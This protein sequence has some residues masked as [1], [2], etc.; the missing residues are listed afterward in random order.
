[1]K[2]AIAGV[3]ALA[4][5]AIAALFAHQTVE[6]DLDYRR[7]IALGDEAVARGQIF[8][9]IE[10]FS[11][12]IALKPT[13]MLGYLKRGEA[14]QRRGETPET[15]MAAL[16]DLRMAFE[17]DP[18]APKA[19]EELG[20][21]NFKLQRY[22]NS[23]DSYEAYLRLDDQSATVFYKLA[24]AARGDGRLGRAVAAL[25][26]AVRLNPSFAEAH[27]MLGLCLRE[28]NQLS[29]ARAAFEQ[30][31][32]VAPAMISAREELADLH[33]LQRRSREEIEQLEALAALDGGKAERIIALGLAYMNAGN[34][35][36]AVTQL[37][38]ASERFPDHP[39]VPAALG[40]VWIRAAETRG[41]PTD[42]NKAIE[43][44]EPVATLPGA[45]SQ[46]LGLYGRALMLAGE[47]ARA[48]QILR[49]AAQRFPV[50]P[51]VLPEFSIAAQRMGHLQDARSSLVQYTALVDDDQEI[52][53]HA[54]R[55]ADLSMQLNDAA[56]AV[57]WYE[58]S[59]ALAR[60]DAS[61]LAREAEALMKAGR[62]KE[63][64]STIERALEEDPGNAQVKAVA[65]TIQTR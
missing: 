1:V 49:Q 45:T 42:I 64:E 30:A 39:G 48:E 25:Q 44:L 54:V 36:L 58:K 2:K 62:Q 6:R 28:R 61:Q 33:H 65:R 37:R 57:Q 21:V 32:R 46:V 43:A 27:Y 19:L 26:Q 7:F 15:L 51:D 47:T 60:P 3:L 18:G 53:T 12:A 8:A 29:Q 10:A 11:G 34:H 40:Q 52:A 9:A 4:T 59:A 5:L 55:I 41:D 20:D 22:K 31:V 35:D 56:T 14:H 38:H 50:D 23:A 16:R 13:S 17:L 24:L 63:A